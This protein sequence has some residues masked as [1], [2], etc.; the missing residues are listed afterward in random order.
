MPHGRGRR[1]G[2]QRSQPG[3]KNSAQ[4]GL[5]D[6]V[7]GEGRGLSQGG[8][9]WP[10]RWGHSDAPQLIPHGVTA[11]TAARQRPAQAPNK[12]R[13]APSNWG[14][15][16]P[17]REGRASKGHPAW[18]ESRPHGVGSA[19]GVKLGWALVR[20]LP[21]G[22]P[23]SGL[24]GVSAPQ[25]ALRGAQRGLCPSGHPRVGSAPAPPAPYP[26]CCCKQ[27]HPHPPTASTARQE[28]SGSCFSLEG[29]RGLTLCAAFSC[30]SSE[31]QLCVT[32]QRKPCPWAPAHQESRTL[33]CL[34][35]FSK[36]NQNGMRGGSQC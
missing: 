9:G 1:G 17:K 12:E 35:G 28:R 14:S 23:W 13:S 27:R 22:S 20:S 8:V 18:A 15:G 11:V 36:E 33:S 5:S 7:G 25:V 24:S 26:N 32:S 19:P 16:Y 21:L 4:I 3:K 34:P 30:N 6:W 2:G 29:S 10:W 31:G